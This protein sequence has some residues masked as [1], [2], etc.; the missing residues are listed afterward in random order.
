MLSR[1]AESLFWIGRYVERADDTARI[2]DAFL[3]RLLEDPWADEDA[4]CRTLLAILGAP[5]AAGPADRPPVTCW[6][7]S[8]FDA[9]E[10]QR[11]RRRARRGPG[12]RARRTRDDLQ[13]D[14]GVP[15]RHLARP[16]V[17]AGRRRAPRAQ[18]LPRLRAG[19][20]RGAG[21]ARRVDD[22]P[23]RRLAVPGA[24]PQPGARRHDRA[25]A[26]HP[27]AH[28]RRGR[29]HGAPC[30]AP[31]APTSRSCAP[32]AATF[33][34]AAGGRVPAAGPAVPA[35]GAARADHRRGVP[36]R[37]WRR[38]PSGPAWP[39]RP[40][41]RSARPGPGWSTPTP[42]PCWPSCR[43]TCGRCSRPAPRR[44]PPSRP[45]TSTQ[46]TP[47][48]WGT[49]AWGGCMSWRLRIRHVTGYKY[50][51]TRLA[52]YNEAR[53]T[54]LTLPG[55]P[56]CSARSR[57]TPGRH[58]LPLLRLL[59]HPGHRVRPAP[60]APAAAGGASSL[61]E[62]SP[63]PLPVVNARPGPSWAATR[64]SDTH[65]ELLTDEPAD[66][67]RRRAGRRGMG[68]GRRPVA[69]GLRGGVVAL[70]T[71]QRRLRARAPPACR[72]SAQEAWK[73]R[74]GVCQDIAHLTVGLLRARGIPARYVSGYLHPKVEAEVGETVAGQS[75]AWVEW[76]AA[77]GPASI[78]PTGCRSARGT[79]WW[80]G[81]ATTTTSRRSRASTTARRASTSGSP[82]RS[83]AWRE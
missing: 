11:D 82:W 15:Q 68:R 31:A 22:E 38:R 40:A 61:V 8:R 36:A 39:T 35:L 45:A 57:C 81:A 30:C 47:V 69:A 7:C 37:R 64:C 23:R 74:K 34:A 59:G 28:H 55:R 56:R 41:G 13:R 66:R 54:P 25:A 63:P 67:R 48:T 49:V 1:I 3:G 14:V 52:S 83:P 18:P 21:R 79:W 46:S 60:A 77:N 32:T 42:P 65:A 43:S 19:A 58:H 10:P 4:A 73:L 33:D 16:A 72:P 80:P 75:H 76:W 53:L 78:R 27:G 17:A 71:G 62:T 70:G 9:D 20:R 5:A 26:V 12:E 2:L 24:G 50:A 29:R 6:S 44:A 51:G